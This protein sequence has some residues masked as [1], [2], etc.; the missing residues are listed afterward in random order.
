MVAVFS[1]ERIDDSNEQAM[2]P[3]HR[4]A[5]LPDRADFAEIR[6]LLGWCTRRHGKGY[7]PV[8]E[9]V[10]PSDEVCYRTI[11]SKAVLSL[12]ILFNPQS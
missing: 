12:H 5:G 11:K 6:E 7:I 9:N 8:G 10:G 4:L 1:L 2:V 3:P